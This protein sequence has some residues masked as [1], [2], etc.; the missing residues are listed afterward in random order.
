MALKRTLCH[1]LALIVF[2]GGHPA[3]SADLPVPASVPAPVVAPGAPND[4]WTGLYLGAHLGFATGRSGWSATQPSGA[5]N[6]SGSLDFTRAFDLFTGTGS[7]LGGVQAGY[8]FMVTSRI[9]AGVEAD[10][11]FPNTIAA[12]Q[13]FMSPFIGAA[14]YRDTV[15]M[16]GTV[17]GRLG[18]DVNG[19][20]YYATG[21]LAWT[22][23]QFTRTQLTDIP[24]GTTPAGTIE[25]AFLGRIGWTAGAGIEA[26]IASGWSG[27]LEY[28]YAQFGHSAVTFPQGGQTFW[29]NLALHEVRAG[30]NYRL[31]EP[32]GD[33]PIPPP[34]ESGDW[35]VHGQTT[36]LSQYAA[37][38]S[39]PYRGANS[40]DS[41]AGRETWDMTAYIGRRLWQGAE[42]W[43]NPEIDQGFGLSGTLGV[44]GFTSGEAYKV[45][46]SYPYVRLPR[47]FIR[48][49][50]NLGGDTQKVESDINQFAGS[51]TADRLVVTLG[52]FSVPDVFDT[53]G[54]AH[55]PRND[56]MNWALV[57]AG[58]FDYA[59]DAWGFTYGAAT[60]WYQGQWTLRAGLFD[61]S[62]VPNS[63]DLDRHFDQFQTIYE[64]EHHHELA[65]QS[66][67]VAVVGFLTRGRMGRFDDAIAL[68][69][70][71]ATPPSTAT[72][73]RYASRAGLNVNLEQQIADGIGLFSR[74]GFADGNVEPYEF[75]DIDRTATVGLS[76]SGKRWNRP[77]DTFGIAGIVNGISAAHRAYLNAGGLGVLV[78]D[79]Q[80]P[81][82][83]YEQI[84]ET[85]YTFPVGAWKATGDYQLIANPGYNR[86]RGPVSVISGR[87][88]RQF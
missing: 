14:N 52:K 31:G 61:M 66:G 82:P 33:A 41:N 29:S 27:K 86:D 9:L 54:Y 47:T 8:N 24:T 35:A 64:L 26:P 62:I 18:Y 85:Y 28:L 25:T 48:Q 87:L 72:V 63:S 20:L 2:A 6:L 3:H 7:Y 42:L 59:A 30:L 22:Y 11:S 55:D 17:R 38:F 40:L 45:G 19:W 80:L 65:G 51:Q 56:F 67:K 76:I 68:G 70:A 57:D 16:F 13:N 77:D 34:L 4:A 79:G 49:T 83:G 21:G 15:E 10:I 37:R 60:E 46:A 36:L 1:G 43:I 73:R 5:P 84:L 69:L 53:I 39:A 23:D 58:T 12:G 50:I 71:T 78:G 75:T 44:A 88:R 74:V 32:A 81:H